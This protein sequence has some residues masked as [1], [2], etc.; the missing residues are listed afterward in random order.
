MKVLA[1]TDFS[2]NA[3][4][5]LDVAA[6]LARHLGDDLQLVHVQAEIP[7]GS[8]SELRLQLRESAEKNLALDAERL[9]QGGLEVHCTVAEGRPDA[10]LIDEA[11]RDNARLIV[12]ASQGH[13]APERW[14]VGRVSERTAENA[15]VPTLVVRSPGPLLEWLSGKR[16]LRL[17]V[18]VDFNSSCDAALTWAAHVRTLGPCDITVC[19]VA[20]VARE[21]SRLGMPAA[22]VPG[23]MPARLQEILERD[24]RERIEAI[25]PNVAVELRVEAGWGTP[26]FTLI[27]IAESIQADLIIT[28]TSQTRG[29]ERL[30]QGSTS[31]RLLSTAPANLL[32][33]PSQAAAVA[34]APTLPEY[35]RVFTATDFSPLG[36]SAIAH[37]YAIVAPGGTVRL[38]HVLEP[39]QVEPPRVEADV[40]E[41]APPQAPV[42][43]PILEAEAQLRGLIPPA[44]AE[45]SITTE[46]RVITSG[47]AAR[48]LAQ[49]A[50]RFGA[51]VI[52]LASHGRS[53]LLASILGSVARDIIDQSRRPV[54]LIRPSAE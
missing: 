30:W 5:A 36:N 14:F 50:E 52:C 46:I 20:W 39:W 42:E 40:I 6:A 12:L 23:K 45:R 4:R 26:D 34:A 38:S 24:L 16:P 7:R 28:G 43:G 8:D 17:L 44:A 49:A 29:I 21:G 51:H 15:A 9:R 54:L 33:V 2:E 1:G 35:S 3:T 13:I 11:A 31:R 53:G 47:D 41:G 48:S 25:L 37:A 18:G 32:C 10:V 22:H 27:E 19:H